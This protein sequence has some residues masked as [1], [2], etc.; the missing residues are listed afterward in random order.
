M[1]NNQMHGTTHAGKTYDMAWPGDTHG[2]GSKPAIPLKKRA[3]F[4]G[5]V[6]GENEEGKQLTTAELRKKWG[7]Q[8]TSDR[9]LFKWVGWAR[10]LE[11]IEGSASG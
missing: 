4:V 2:G 1:A 10:K 6:R 9:T 8:L 5:D 11:P 7:K 3:D